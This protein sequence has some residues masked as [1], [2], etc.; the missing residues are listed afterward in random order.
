[1]HGSL[2]DAKRKKQKRRRKESLLKDE[3]CRG[4]VPVPMR[5]GPA[6]SPQLAGSGRKHDH[7]RPPPAL[8]FLMPVFRYITSYACPCRSRPPCSVL[9]P[10]PPTRRTPPRTVLCLPQ[11]RA[12]PATH[13][14]LHTHMLVSTYC[15]TCHP[16]RV[17]SYAPE[18]LVF[19][20]YSR[21]FSFAPPIT[22][23]HC[24]AVMSVSAPAKLMFDWTWRAC[25]P[26]PG[27]ATWW[28]F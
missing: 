18:F 9:E 3:Y 28:L 6:G 17:R 8:R 21:F 13:I 22:R 19:S 5:R 1:M 16:S 26:E 15:Y 4:G 14:R 25:G 10:P 24:S 20:L 7:D 27:C 2:E 12:P 11:Y 23:A